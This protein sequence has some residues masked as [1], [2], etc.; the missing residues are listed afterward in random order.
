M[1]DLTPMFRKY[2]ICGFLVTVHIRMWERSTVHILFPAVN[3]GDILC[4]GILNV[5]KAILNVQP[6]SWERNVASREPHTQKGQCDSLVLDFMN[7]LTGT[8]IIEGVC[9]LY[10]RKH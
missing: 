5:P 1:L 7:D 3:N 4:K 9:E 8:I 2:L 10:C 6:S